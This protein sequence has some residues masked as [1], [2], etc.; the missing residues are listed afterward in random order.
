MGG[1]RRYVPGAVLLLALPA[2]VALQRA[3]SS[4]T[5]ARSAAATIKAPA[6]PAAMPHWKFVEMNQ[7]PE[8]SAVIDASAPTRGVPHW[9]FV[10]MNQL[11][12]TA[13]DEPIVQP[14][15]PR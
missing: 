4:G 5:P 13:S 11:P 12:E 14:N 6:A 10:E 2:G 1:S 3:L 8:S 7:M 9:K 15:G